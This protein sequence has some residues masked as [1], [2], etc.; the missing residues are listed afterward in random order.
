MRRV[1]LLVLL[2]L[3]VPL[4]ASA[5]SIDITNEGGSI[6]SSNGGLA[7]SGSTIVVYNAGTV[8]TGSLGTVTFQ[9][10]A[11][12][13][14]NINDGGTLAAGGSITITGNGSNGVPNGAIFV[15]SFGAGTKWEKVG[16][17]YDLLG[18]LV[19]APGQ[20]GGIS[21][22]TVQATVGPNGIQLASGDIS[23]STTAVPEPGT[24]ALLGT[25]LVGI[26]GVLRR[27]FVR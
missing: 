15:G 3:A 21:E 11:F 27:R 22:L 18:T 5:S 25:G 1:I 23:I 19:G 7:L 13:S 17:G 8:I 12:T 26:G 20:S 16:G 24:L 14:G 6:T 4:A 9:T 2:A 10:G